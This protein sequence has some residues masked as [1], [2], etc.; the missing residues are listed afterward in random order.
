MKLFESHN[1]D[2]INVRELAN[3]MTSGQRTIQLPAFQRDAVWDEAH[4]QLLWDSIFRGYPIS[5]IIFAKAGSTVVKKTLSLLK[6]QAQQTN[7]YPETEYILLDGQQRSRAIALGLKPWSS[8]D[9]ARMWIDLGQLDNNACRFFVCSLRK[10]WGIGATDA[11]QREALAPESNDLRI[12]ADTLFNT[13]PLKASLP[14]PLAELIQ[15]LISGDTLSWKSLIPSKKASNKEADNLD[16]L[17]AS[18]EKAVSYCVPI[19]LV[20]H[21]ELD[22]D[23]LGEIFIRLNRQGVPMSAD[24][25]FFSALKVLWPQAHDL[26]WEVF[27]DADTGRFLRPTSIVHLATRLVE[28]KKQQ[29]VVRLDQKTFKRL[30]QQ[31]SAG[32]ESFLSQMQSL[33]LP[34][35]GASNRSQIHDALRC[36]RQTLIYTPTLSKDDPGLPAPLLANLRAKVWHTLTAWIIQNG[37][38]IT[39]ENRLEMIR[40][41]LFE[42]FYINPSKSSTSLLSLPFKQSYESKEVFPGKTIYTELLKANLIDRKIFSIQEYQEKID[43]EKP[44]F[45]LLHSEQNL[46]MWVQR[47]YVH[48]W[49][50]Y[51]DPT[52]HAGQDL[53]YDVDHIVPRAH[54][55]MQGRSYPWP[56]IFWDWRDSLWQSPGNFRIWPKSINRGDGQSNLKNKFILG[57]NVPDEKSYLRRYGL[58]SAQNVREASYILDEQLGKWEIVDNTNDPYNWTEVRIQAFREAADLRRIQMYKSLFDTIKWDRWIE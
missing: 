20:E 29:D 23:T 32:D 3:A 5:S 43:A 14:V 52:I 47:K 1:P 16:A 18:I 40:Y 44:Q 17:L 39:P 41:A 54:K 21:L 53:P 31:T 26:V 55:N 35:A 15:K 50:P 6:N 30:S 11:M 49:F 57:N 38:E 8:G 24:D 19:Y 2:V 51:F 45:Y 4:I 25:L 10:P 27:S 56:A 7:Q 13:W 58:N 48:D 36:A 42:Y 22:T 12:D 34:S 33:L 37:T 46:T 28:V 9:S